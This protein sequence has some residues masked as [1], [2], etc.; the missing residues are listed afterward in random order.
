[1]NRSFQMNLFLCGALSGSHTTIQRH[2]RQATYMQKA[3][4]NRWKITSPWCW[5]LKHL[6]WFFNHHLKN[7]SP[8]TRYYYKLTAQLILKKLDKNF[9]LSISRHTYNHKT[10]VKAQKK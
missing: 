2:L 1:M 10:Q 6:H 5:K 8:P 9:A 7:H 3:I 4:C